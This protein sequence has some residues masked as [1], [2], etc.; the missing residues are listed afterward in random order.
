MTKP[1]EEKIDDL[2]VAVLAVT[3]N[4][5]SVQTKCSAFEIALKTLYVN[6]HDNSR[7]GSQANDISRGYRQD[8]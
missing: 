4:W 1:M 6:F 5:A 8:S 7:S 3:N 2:S